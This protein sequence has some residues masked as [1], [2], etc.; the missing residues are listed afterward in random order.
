MICLKSPTAVMTSRRAIQEK[1]SH[2][3]RWYSS[4]NSRRASILKVQSNL[5]TIEFNQMRK[6]CGEENVAI[7]ANDAHFFH[8]LMLHITTVLL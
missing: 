2:K 3:Y 8:V 5:P 6:A 4:H 7:R 1:N